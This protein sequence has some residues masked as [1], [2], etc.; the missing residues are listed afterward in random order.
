MH[1]IFENKQNHIR[2]FYHG[3]LT[4][5]WEIYFCEILIDFERSVQIFIHSGDSACVSCTMEDESEHLLDRQGN[6]ILPQTMRPVHWTQ[7]ARKSSI[8]APASQI[9]Q[10]KQRTIYYVSSDINFF[11]GMYSR[12]IF[13]S[14]LKIKFY[15]LR[16]LYSAL[17]KN[18]YRYT[19]ISS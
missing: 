1:K 17:I 19:R 11:L 16:S 9:A 3:L 14:F 5:S 6:S 12:L 8:S 4:P 2:I 15:L 18:Y 7:E 10:N 13:C